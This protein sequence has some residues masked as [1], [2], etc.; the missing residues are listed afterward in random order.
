M[1]LDQL[2]I[3][4]GVAI[5]SYFLK[6]EADEVARVVRGMGMLYLLLEDAGLVS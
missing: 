1:A 2:E 4:E 6:N 3:L 5:F